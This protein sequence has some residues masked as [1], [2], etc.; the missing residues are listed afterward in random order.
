[1]KLADFKHIYDIRSINLPFELKFV[2]QS[3]FHIR[4]GHAYNTIRHTLLLLYIVLIS[5]L[6]Q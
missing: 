1:M 4:F 5:L 3:S 2:M 6:L